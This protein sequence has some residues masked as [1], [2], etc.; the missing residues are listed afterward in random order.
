VTVRKTRLPQR[1]PGA[2]LPSEALTPQPRYIGRA[3]VPAKASSYANDTSTMER[4]S[5][6]L[7][8]PEA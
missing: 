7:R 3:S 5:R 6:A 1:V 2:H 8:R 4:L